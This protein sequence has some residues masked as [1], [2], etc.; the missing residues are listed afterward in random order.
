MVKK[1][2][3]TFSLTS[4]SIPQPLSSTSKTMVPSPSLTRKLTVEVS[5]FDVLQAS[6]AFDERHRN[7]HRGDEQHASSPG[8]GLRNAIGPS[9]HDGECTGRGSD[10]AS[11]ARA[12]DLR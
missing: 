4:A 10:A 1:L 9:R 8:E 12:R 2:V 11:S 7:R 6:I 5:F 3:N